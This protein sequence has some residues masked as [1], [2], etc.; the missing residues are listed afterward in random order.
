MKEFVSFKTEEIK[1]IMEK[2][3]LTANKR[4]EGLYKE[5]IDKLHEEASLLKE[6]YSNTI[7]SLEDER[8]NLKG[9]LDNIH[10][11][12]FYKIYRKLGWTK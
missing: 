8:N 7:K 12:K 4:M 1:Q 6:K 10:N 5:K 2:D 11:T 9:D 3:F